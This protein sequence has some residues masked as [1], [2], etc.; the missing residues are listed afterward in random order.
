MNEIA[1]FE[2]E[3]LAGLRCCGRLT[4]RKYPVT[5]EQHWSNMKEMKANTKA[6][7]KG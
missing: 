6:N 5:L 7:M 4:C 2:I 1:I 3:E